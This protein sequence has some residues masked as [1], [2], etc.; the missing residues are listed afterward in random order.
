VKNV[1]MF[2]SWLFF[3]KIKIK[4]RNIVAGKESHTDRASSI[5]GEDM[6]FV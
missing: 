1:R 6:P 4:E 3:E 5:M 2:L